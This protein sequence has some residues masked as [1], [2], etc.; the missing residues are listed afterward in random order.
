MIL[1]A[2]DAAL[3]MVNTDL[4]VPISHVKVKIQQLFIWCVCNKLAIDIDKTYF[5]LFHALNKPVPDDFTVIVITQMMI[6]RA[7]EI[8]YLGLV[9]DEKL[10]Y[11][12][13]V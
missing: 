4:K 11:N 5:V 8:R 10:N 7:T 3:N 13:H 12:E 2:D 6:K 9:L 1:F